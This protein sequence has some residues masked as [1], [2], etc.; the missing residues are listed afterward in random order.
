MKQ[1]AVGTGANAARAA[2]TSK[3]K[4]N[5]CKAKKDGEDESLSGVT[6]SIGVQGVSLGGTSVAQFR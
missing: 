6:D 4:K 1:K 3:D 2:S 5:E